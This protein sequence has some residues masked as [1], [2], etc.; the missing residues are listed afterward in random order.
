MELK[1]E[2]EIKLLKSRF[3]RGCKVMVDL[4]EDDHAIPAGSV[5]TVSTIDDA[6]QIHLEEF[7]LAIIPGVDFFHRV[8]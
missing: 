3:P 1:S 8:G 7:G 6:G 2:E 4:M 5:G